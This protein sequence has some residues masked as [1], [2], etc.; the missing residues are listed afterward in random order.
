MCWNTERG[1]CKECA[2]EVEAEYAAAQVE[3]T[4]EQGREAIREAKYV[5]TE[6]KER[7][8]GC[9]GRLPQMRS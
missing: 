1:L 5:S 8:R 9:D 6:D 3:A 4:I 7:L 2:P